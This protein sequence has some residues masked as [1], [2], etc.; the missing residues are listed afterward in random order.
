[1]R[2][3]HDQLWQG[4]SGDVRDLRRVREQGIQALIDLALPDPPLT[5]GREVTYCRF[6]I[7]DGG[8]NELWLLRAAIDTAASLIRSQTPT[9]IFCSAGLSRSPSIAAAALS[10]ALGVS[11]QE[12]LRIVIAGCH[13]P[14][15]GRAPADISPGLWQQVLAALDTKT[16]L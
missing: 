3:V 7:E 16:T 10:T 11:P 14:S 1:V 4:H 13:G 12:A 8:G 2:R 15:S 5:I 6:P 9:L